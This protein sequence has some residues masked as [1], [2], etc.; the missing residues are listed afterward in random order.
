MDLKLQTFLVDSVVSTN[1]VFVYI[2]M[3][4][5]FFS[6]VDC[7]KSGFIAVVFINALQI[8]LHVAG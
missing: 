6:S 8:Y 1:I 4:I 7:R 2:S 3:K 5:H